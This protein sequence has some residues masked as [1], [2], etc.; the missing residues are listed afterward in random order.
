[1]NVISA[2][3]EA[4]GTLARLPHALLVLENEDDRKTLCRMV[5]ECGVQPV[6]CSTLQD[7]KALVASDAISIA[8]CENRLDDGDY[9]D[10]LRAVRS[11]GRTIPVVVCSRQLDLS[12]YLDAM[13]MGAYDFVVRPYQEADLAWIME[14]ALW[15]V[16]GARLAGPSAH[17]SAGGRFYEH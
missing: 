6:P 10:F 12:L 1:M 14:G 3:S 11:T 17:N 5:A 13:E 4:S 15:K 16:A 7:A 8:F 2:F 9:M